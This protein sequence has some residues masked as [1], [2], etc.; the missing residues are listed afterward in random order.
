MPETTPYSPEPMYPELSEAFAALF[1]RMNYKRP[2]GTWGQYNMQQP[3]SPTANEQ[4]IT[5]RDE[6]VDQFGSPKS[7]VDR[8]PL[9]A[10][11]N[12][13]KLPEVWDSWQ[14][15]DAGT[16]FLASYLGG[17]GGL[18]ESSPFHQGM[19]DNGGFGGPGTGGMK[20]ALEYGAASDAGQFL[21]NMAQFGVASETSGRPLA[22]L[23]Y[24]SGENNASKYLL[25]FLTGDFNKYKAPEVTK[26]K[27]TRK[28]Q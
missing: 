18:G 16:Q 24:G 23:A 2:D 8:M 20:S 13:T 3:W 26:T 4:G 21:S 19:M 6:G 10:D 5:F 11:P 7:A 15:W 22:N 1:G 12:Q 9:F 14:P 27:R 28:A 17:G 25:P